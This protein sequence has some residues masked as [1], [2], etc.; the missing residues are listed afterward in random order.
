MVIEL[1]LHYK[2]W[3]QKQDPEKEFQWGMVAKTK[4][5]LAVVVTK[6]F[7]EL[8]EWEKELQFQMHAERTLHKFL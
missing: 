4:N 5:S 6:R 2:K 8:S 3:L 7:Y 1:T